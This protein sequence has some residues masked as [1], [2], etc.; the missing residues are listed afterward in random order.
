MAAQT[1]K[2]LLAVP[3]VARNP[4][5]AGAKVDGCGCATCRAAASAWQANR[6]RLIAYG[7]W[8]PFV[9]AE[10]VRQHIRT[11]MTAGVGHARVATLAGVGVGTVSRI[12]YG[13][14]GRPPT[15]RIRP[16]IADALLAVTP[17]SANLA[18]GAHVD[19]TGT[20][21]RMQ[22]MARAGWSIAD[23]A[24]RLGREVRN[25]THCL[26]YDKVTAVTARA[27]AALYDELYWQVPPDS[28]TKKRT[29]TW[30]TKR[31]WLPPQAWV[32]DIDDPAAQPNMGAPKD[33]EP[34]LELVCKA[35]GGEA[36]W[37]QLNRA[38]RVAVCRRLLASGLG[39]NAIARR[40]RASDTVIGD[41]LRAN[42]LVA[43]NPDS[44]G[45]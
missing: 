16:H 32:D 41:F 21:R 14:P 45:A 36:T 10:P 40:V 43:A 42:G 34:D 35:V 28:P 8:R 11:L 2:Q 7:Q 33:S 27:V 9:D 22:A 25:H 30:A 19:A 23:Q 26:N 29:I 5:L 4:G 13:A 18:D 17:T 20:R 39:R 3:C 44:R 1:I 6:T 37:G 15:R 24:R 38:E 31:G 12:L